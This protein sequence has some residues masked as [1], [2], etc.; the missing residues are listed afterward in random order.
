MPPAGPGCGV[1]SWP[2]WGARDPSGGDY[3]VLGPCCNNHRRDVVH[4]A[5]GHAGGCC[6]ASRVNGSGAGLWDQSPTAP[7]T[8]P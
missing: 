8:G 7:P 1:V 2:T 3:P 4:C 5:N 6:N